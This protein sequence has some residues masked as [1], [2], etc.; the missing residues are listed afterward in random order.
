MKD[1]HEMLRHLGGTRNYLGYAYTAHALRLI[2]QEPERLTLVTKWLYPDVAKA[3][4]TSWQAV[5]RDIRTMV[6]IIW[7]RNPHLLERLAGRPMLKR[8]GNA[9]FLDIVSRTLYG[10]QGTA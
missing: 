4:G 1:I 3:F 7:E 9:E 10:D 5:E 2:R 6:W 8:P